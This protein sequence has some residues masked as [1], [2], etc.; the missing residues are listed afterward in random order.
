[1]SCI[2]QW[3]DANFICSFYTLRHNLAKTDGNGWYVRLKHITKYSIRKNQNLVVCLVIWRHYYNQLL[4]C[5][6]TWS[7]GPSRERPI[8]DNDGY[9]KMPIRQKQTEKSGPT[10]TNLQ[11]KTILPSATS[12]TKV[13]CKGTHYPN[14]FRN[15]L[16]V[17]VFGCEVLFT[18]STILLPASQ[19]HCQ[20][21]L[22]L[23]GRMADM[24]Y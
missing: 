13:K 18:D 23:L 17:Y 14:I 9:P 16:K 6:V 21:M 15:I 5:I 7:W 22:R 4:H 10:M 12:F 8:R 2:V 20:R 19:L 24:W 11:T 3:F 1:M